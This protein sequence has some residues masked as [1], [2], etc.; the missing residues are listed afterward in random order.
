MSYGVVDMLVSLIAASPDDAIVTESFHTSVAMLMGSHPK[1]CDSPPLPLHA[2][3]V[4]LDPAQPRPAA[5]LS[6][7]ALPHV[8]TIESAVLIKWV[9]V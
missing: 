4:T 7:A 6:L 3:R 2:Q 8:Q 5:S 9:C 1:A